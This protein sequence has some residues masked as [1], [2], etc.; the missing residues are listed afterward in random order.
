[1]ALLTSFAMSWSVYQKKGNIAYLFKERYTSVSKDQAY[2]SSNMM[3]DERSG[4]GDS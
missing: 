1:M 4:G 3:M 2:I